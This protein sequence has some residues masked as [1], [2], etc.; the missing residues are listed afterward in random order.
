MTKIIYEGDISLSNIPDPIRTEETIFYQLKDEDLLVPYVAV[1]LAY[2]INN[3][4]IPS[5]QNFLREINNKYPEKKIFVCQHILVNQLDFG[6][7][8]VFTPHTVKQDNY[9]FIPHYNPVYEIPPG[10]VELKERKLKFSFI[11]DYNTNPLRGEISRIN[12]PDILSQE[13]G[14]WFFSHDKETQEILKI[15]YKEVL[16]NTQFPL[17][18]PGTGP[19]TLRFFE[20]LSTGGIPILFNDLKIPEKLDKL[21]IRSTIEDLRNGNIFSVI[22]K[23]DAEERSK[24][25]YDLYWSEYSNPKLGNPIINKFK[26]I[27]N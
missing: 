13:T 25:I 24:E 11:G 26:N 21:V 16:E 5:T 3:L 27:N 1:P 18:P 22:E 6:D 2:R 10:R 19:S 9:F 17:C 7:N 8:F 15:R 12:S 14:K 4:G 20:A 23:I